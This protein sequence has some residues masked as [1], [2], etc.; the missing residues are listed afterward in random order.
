MSRV[1]N[2][3]KEA[4]QGSDF[5]RLKQRAKRHDIKTTKATEA[6][7][8]NLVEQNKKLSGQVLLLRKLLK[9]AY[10]ILPSALKLEFDKLHQE[11]DTF[12]DLEV[13][14]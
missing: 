10:R 11:L 6:L 8:E 7:V 12:N 2:I 3:D 5:L 1:R 9:G 4:D 13:H 14:P